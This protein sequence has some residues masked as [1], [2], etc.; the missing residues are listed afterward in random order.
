MQ[1][2]FFF[3]ALGFAVV[4]GTKPAQAQY[5][6]WSYYP[7]LRP[8]YPYWDGYGWRYGYYPPPY[9]VPPPP[10]R[11]PILAVPFHHRSTPRPVYH[12]RAHYHRTLSHPSNHGLVNP[13]LGPL[14]R[15]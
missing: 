11:R 9:I 13:L 4:I 1:R 7:P 8:Y 2:M 10:E 15:R 6:G 5:Y 3:I 12:I 14:P